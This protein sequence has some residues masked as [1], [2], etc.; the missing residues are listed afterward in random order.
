MVTVRGPVDTE[1][2]IKKIEKIIKILRFKT[3]ATAPDTLIDVLFSKERRT[4]CGHCIGNDSP[5]I[6]VKIFL[7]EHS[8]KK[9]LLHTL[10]HELI[11]AKQFLTK[12]FITSFPDMTY[13]KGV[14]Y[15]D[16]SLSD[17]DPSL[18][19]EKDANRVLETL[20]HLF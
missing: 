11:H 15:K 20:I 7:P 19:W 1:Y 16:T 3:Q 8:T 6:F 12:Q 17:E 13:Y 10:I 18:P 2:Y 14:F 5:R 4:Y 9:E